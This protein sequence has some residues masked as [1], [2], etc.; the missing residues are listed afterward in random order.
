MH[1]QGFTFDKNH[2]IDSHLDPHYI[3]LARIKVDS[4]R[5]LADLFLGNFDSQKIDFIAKL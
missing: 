2:R 4:H 3:T 5:E 1:L